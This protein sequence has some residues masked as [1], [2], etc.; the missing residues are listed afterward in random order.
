[1]AGP[2]II[3]GRPDLAHLMA[4]IEDVMVSTRVVDQLGITHEDQTEVLVTY[5][6]KVRHDPFMSASVCLGKELGYQHF[7]IVKDYDSLHGPADGYLF[8]VKVDSSMDVEGLNGRM[9]RFGSE[10]VHFRRVL[11]LSHAI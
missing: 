1:M 8:I 4:P 10:T 6:K 9:M 11:K 7:R 2:A 5:V 3:V